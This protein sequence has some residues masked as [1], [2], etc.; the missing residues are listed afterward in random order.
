MARRALGEAGLAVVQAVAAVLDGPALVACSGGADSLALAAGAAI[1]A[2]RAGTPLRAVVVDHGLQ[3]GSAAVAARVAAQLIG[4]GIATDVVAVTV[5]R[6]PSGPEAAARAAR[7]RALADR[8]APGEA[9]L[10]GHT[11]DDQAESVLLGLARGSGTRSLAGMPARRGPFVRPLLGLRSATTRQACHEFGLEWL[12]DPHNADSGFARVRARRSVLPLLEAELGP[13]IA[14]ALARTAAL[15]AADAD[16]LDSLAAAELAGR[17]PALEAAWLGGLPEA[18]RHRVLRDWL[19]AAGARDLTAGHLRSVAALAT[20][21]HGQGALDLPGV[22]VRRVAGALRVAA[23]P[24][25]TG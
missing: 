9:V 22:T 18:L 13:G 5:A 19:R 3:P 16:L 21:W 4:L 20:D 12:E 6:D 25:A 14:E 7:Y 15:A 11:L 24:S 1:A 2:G 8:A 17:G 10:L 23:P